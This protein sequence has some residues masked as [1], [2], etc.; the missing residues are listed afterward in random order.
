MCI[1]D[2]THMYFNVHM[3]LVLWSMQGKSHSSLKLGG[4]EMFIKE[5]LCAVGREESVDA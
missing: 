4:E 3:W 1:S 5:Y 2:G